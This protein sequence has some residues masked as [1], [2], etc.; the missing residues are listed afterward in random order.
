MILY[1][2]HLGSL[3]LSKE[4][5]PMERLYCDQCGDWDWKLGEVNTFQDVLDLVTDEDGF[6]PWSEEM[7]EEIKEDLAKMKGGTE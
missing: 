6:C 4:E 1:E 5:I 2:G 7:L 3:Y